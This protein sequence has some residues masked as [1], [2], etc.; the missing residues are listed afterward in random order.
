MSLLC[1][2]SDRS[3]PFNRLFF[4][5]HSSN[6]GREGPHVTRCIVQFRC[7]GVDFERGVHADAPL[8]VRCLQTLAQCGPSAHHAA[9][10]CAA[11][12]CCEEVFQSYEWMRRDRTWLSF[13][14]FLLAKY[15]FPAPLTPRGKPIWN[16]RVCRPSLNGEEK[17]QVLPICLSSRRYEVLNGF[18]VDYLLCFHCDCCFDCAKKT[19]TASPVRKM[20]PLSFSLEP[21]LP[22]ARPNVATPLKPV[23]SMEPSVKPV[24]PSVMVHSGVTVETKAKAVGPSNHV[25]TTVGGDQC[26]RCGNYGQHSPWCPCLR[27]LSTPANVA[28]KPSA[29]SANVK[30]PNC[31]V[32]GLTVEG[33]WRECPNDKCVECL[34]CNLI[35]LLPTHLSKLW[36]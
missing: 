9:C 20:S 1:V 35:G 29:D 33:E 6:D 21:Q 3:H 13:C 36:A 8:C 17:F 18:F 25:S 4:A 10:V 12:F 24:T 15:V 14:A 34:D 11:T 32:C 27:P 5:G 16:L 2:H 31:S 26:N 28:A 30:V 23:V 19:R 22:I 7:R